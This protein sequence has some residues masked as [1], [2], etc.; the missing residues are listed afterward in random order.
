M[1]IQAG[2]LW[3]HEG[4][5]F[6]GLSLSGIHTS[7][8]IP[9]HQI[10]FDVAQGLP[11]A[12]KMRKFFITHGHLDHAAGIPYIISQKAMHNEPAPQ[13]YMPAS[14]ADPITEIIRLWEKIE[15]H[16]YKFEFHKV[17]KKTCVPL[18]LQHE[19]RCF[20]TV[21]RIE[22]FG[23]SLV[24]KNK[25]LKPEFQNLS[26]PEIQQAKASGLVVDEIQEKILMSF[27]GD[28]QIEFLDLSPEIKKSRILFLEATYLDERKS[29]SDAKKWGHTHLDEI[30]PRLDEIESEKIALIHVSSRYSTPEIL[31][32][33]KRKIPLIHQERVILFPGR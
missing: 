8:S 13:F 29:I 7:L 4:L 14:L 28:T 30:I 12:V 15:E 27:T 25:K 17:D 3:Q 33:L 9:L 16:Q 1:G 2:S 21:H 24:N 23:Y 20:P 19:V 31:E 18:N 6:F 22:S 10:C 26:G 11:F 32:I 5:D